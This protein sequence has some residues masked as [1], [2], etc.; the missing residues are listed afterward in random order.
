MNAGKTR[1][2]RTAGMLALLLTTAA[3]ACSDPV[4][5]DR[6][7]LIRTPARRI[8]SQVPVTFVVSP[9]STATIQF[10]WSPA[11]G[12]R[13]YTIT[14][15]RG[16]NE[17]QVERLEA[18]FSTPLM[19]WDITN[20]QIEEVPVRP[21]TEDTRTVRLVRTELPM[22]DVAAALAAAGVPA[23]ERTYTLLSVFAHNGGDTWRS[24]SLTPI[25]FTLNP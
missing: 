24:S 13:T 4:S 14:F 23:G 10:E 9:A 5:P 18:D 21:D 16:E 11:A 3:T 2:A 22:S 7:F 25:I 12:A 17:A 19:S 8:T 20:P 1:R 6:D 15:W